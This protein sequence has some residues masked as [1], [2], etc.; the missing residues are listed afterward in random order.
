MPFGKSS[1]TRHNMGTNKL[2]KQFI[3]TIFIIASVAALLI[4]VLLGVLLKTIGQKQPQAPLSIEEDQI[5]ANP[6]YQNPDPLIT[7]NP[8]LKDMLGGPIISK[9]DP[10]LGDREARVTIVQYSDFS[11]QFCQV[12]EQHLKELVAKNKYRVRLFWKDYPESNEDSESFRAAVAARCA[13]AQDQFW[14]YHDLLY[15]FNSFDPASFVRIAELLKLDLNQFNICLSSE[16]AKQLV[17]DNIEEADALNINGVPFIFI[18]N[19]SV[20]GASSYPELE[21]IVKSEL[22]Q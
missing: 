14:P 13:Q 10:S 20:L 16:E 22:A 2:E 17:R 4:M 1:N 19:Q 18:N 6:N 5:S 12:Q 21:N 11:C 15:E 9:R 7:K 8:S 3:K